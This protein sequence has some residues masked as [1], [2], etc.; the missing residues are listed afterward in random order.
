L[1]EN[2]SRKGT[3]ENTKREGSEKGKLKKEEVG[4]GERGKR[5]VARD[6]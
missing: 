1:E 4:R 6:G 2:I 3:K 5:Q